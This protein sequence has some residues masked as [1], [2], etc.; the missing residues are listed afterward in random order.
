M[1]VGSLHPSWTLFTPDNLSLGL[2]KANCRSASGILIK[3]VDTI[4]KDTKQNYKVFIVF[5]N[6]EIM[7][8][9]C[10]EQNMF[11]FCGMVRPYQGRSYGSKIDKLIK[12]TATCSFFHFSTRIW[13][14]LQLDLTM[15][16][17]T[18]RNGICHSM[19]PHCSW[20][21]LLDSFLADIPWL[22]SRNNFTIA[23]RVRKCTASSIFAN[24]SWSFVIQN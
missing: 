1:L 8:H 14:Y 11:F 24:V 7:S 6:F 13:Y 12:W 18:S 19:S 5:V 16:M 22:S 23:F 4:V 20:E 15:T 21:A 2:I 9:H 17:I 3:F 10:R